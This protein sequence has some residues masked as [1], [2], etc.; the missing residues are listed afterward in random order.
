MKISN[1][2][3]EKMATQLTDD[4]VDALCKIDY[5]LT[6]IGPKT[7]IFNAILKRLFN[8]EE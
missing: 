4:I 3:K 2:E 1:E 5:D 8:F 7:V 6:G